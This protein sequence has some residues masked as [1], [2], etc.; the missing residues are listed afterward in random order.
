MQSL[1]ITYLEPRVCYNF[2]FTGLD[3][4]QNQS[5]LAHPSRSRANNGTKLRWINWN[6]TGSMLEISSVTVWEKKHTHTH[7]TLQLGQALVRVCP[8]KTYS[9]NNS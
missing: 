1:F 4:G 8:S 5:A 9:G 7:T 2:I 6:P 3:E